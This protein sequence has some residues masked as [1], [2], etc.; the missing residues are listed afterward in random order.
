MMRLESSAKAAH[1]QGRQ[2]VGSPD[3]E[4]LQANFRP[5][6]TRTPSLDVIVGDGTF[7]EKVRGALDARKTR[8][9]QDKVDFTSFANFM[10][11]VLDW[12]VKIV[13]YIAVKVTV[14]GTWAGYKSKHFH[15][16]KSFYS[17]KTL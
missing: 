7:E 1:A 12:G 8:S 3:G 10:G 6:W 5:T 14:I 4:D 16:N 13:N 11:H 2:Y 17:H 15:L 9:Q